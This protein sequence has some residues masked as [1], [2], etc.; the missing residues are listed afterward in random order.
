MIKLKSIPS[1]GMRDKL[2]RQGWRFVDGKA[3]ENE[4]GFYP[5]HPKGGYYNTLVAVDFCYQMERGC[6]GYHGTVAIPPPTVP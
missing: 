3:S 4:R 1:A 2:E 6:P 5:A